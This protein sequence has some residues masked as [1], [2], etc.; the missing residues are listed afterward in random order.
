MHRL[1]GGCHC[2]N[3]SVAVALTRPPEAYAPR[4]CDCDFCRKHG[5]AYVS[6]PDGSLAVRIKDQSSTMHYRQ[7]SEA[8]E[9]LICAK[10]GI[11]VLALYRDQDGVAYGAVNV[12][13]L[14]GPVLLG[15]VQPVSP[16]QLSKDDKVVRWKEIWFR[17]VTLQAPRP[18]P[19]RE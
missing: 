15:Q 12:R 6:D 3:I 5:A 1:T 17:G 18:A 13:T 16:K 4:C 2:G 11:Y 19:A 14:D 8:A 7:G 9:C 10:C